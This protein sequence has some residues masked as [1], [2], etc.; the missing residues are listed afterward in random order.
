MKTSRKQD[1]INT[2]EDQLVAHARKIKDS[3]K[4]NLIFLQIL[5]T[6]FAEGKENENQSNQNQL[7]T[8][9]K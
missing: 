4:I 8:L 9:L 7:I 6:C 2:S 1:K 3:L 5:R